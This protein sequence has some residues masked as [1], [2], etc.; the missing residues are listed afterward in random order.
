MA[1]G[2]LPL[3]AHC[4]SVMENLVRILSRL[5]YS[6]YEW[7]LTCAIPILPLHTIHTKTKRS[8]VANATVQAGE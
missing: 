3:F 8:F 6:S 4:G 7:M 5:H 1:D 2:A